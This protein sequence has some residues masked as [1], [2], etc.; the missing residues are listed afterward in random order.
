MKREPLFEQ[1]P[2]EM[3]DQ[4]SRRVQGGQPTTDVTVSAHIA[5]NA[6]VFAAI[7]ALHVPLGARVADITYGK[8]VFWQQVPVGNYRLQFSDLDAKEFAV[9]EKVLRKL[10]VSLDKSPRALRAAA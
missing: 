10:I 5:G 1:L 6:E 9:L 3:L 4:P 7:A 8:G 2:L